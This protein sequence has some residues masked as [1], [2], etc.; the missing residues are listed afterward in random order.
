M[1]NKVVDTLLPKANEKKIKLTLKNQLEKEQ[2]LIKVDPSRLE[3]ILVNLVGN[4]IK[5][6]EAGSVEVIVGEED[7]KVKISVEDTG[8]G[9]SSEE[10]ESLFGKFN[11][12]K[13]EKTSKVEGTGLGLWITK[14]LTEQM[15]GDI[16]VES[17]KGKGSRFFV[18]F[19]KTETKNS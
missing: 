7:K 10:K 4:S 12:I 5:Y 14:Q 11:R 1:A 2:D 19:D 3:Q 9:M 13:N 8:I 16:S 6:T 17:I 15:K 18:V